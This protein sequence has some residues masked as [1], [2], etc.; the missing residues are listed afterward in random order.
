MDLQKEID[1]QKICD[2]EFANQAEFKVLMDGFE[3]TR[4]TLYDGQHETQI[5]RDEIKKHLGLI[6]KVPAHYFRLKLVRHGIL[7]YCENAGKNIFI[8]V[9]L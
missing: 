5:L 6:Y 7:K 2:Q 1:H 4:I 3:I 8:D 9:D